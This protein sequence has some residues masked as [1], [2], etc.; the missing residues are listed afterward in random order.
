MIIQTPRLRLRP[1]TDADMDP[2]LA[3]AADPDVMRYVS[4]IPISR[5]MAEALATRARRLLDAKGYGYWTIDVTGGAS[6]AG[7]ILLQDVEFTAAFT[8][9]IEVGWLLPREHWGKGYATEGGRFA[10]DYALAVLKLDE[11]VALTA[12]GNLPSQRVMQRIG[13]THDPADDF[14]HPHTL[15]TRLQRCVLYRAK[16]D[17]NQTQDQRKSSVR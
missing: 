3:M 13:M 17:P 8:P 4:P 9:A 15:G 12:E 14:D 16:R 7:V 11:V 5:S 10:L 6:F 1:M 2:F